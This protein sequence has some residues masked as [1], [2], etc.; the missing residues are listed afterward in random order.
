MRWAVSLA[1]AI[2]ACRGGAPADSDC[3][4]VRAAAASVPLRYQGA[5][6]ADKLRS[7]SFANP[8]VE[9]AARAGDVGKLAAVCGPLS[10]MT[11]D[12]R[13]ADCALV[14]MWVTTAEEEARGTAIIDPSVPNAQFRDPEIGA[15]M[16]ELVASGWMPGGPARATPDPRPEKLRTL[17]GYPSR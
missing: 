1:L 11:I 6:V 5:A 12:A 17:C 3:A 7:A 14:R 8:Q 10:A 4:R 2:T 15:A 16:R 9:A 13:Q